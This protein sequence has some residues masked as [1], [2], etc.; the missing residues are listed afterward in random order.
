MNEHPLPWDACRGT[1]PHP[2]S[3]THPSCVPVFRPQSDDYESGSDTPD[4]AA[5][6][7]ELL[8]SVR[9]TIGAFAAPD[10]IH[11]A[12]RYNSPSLNPL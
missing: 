2:S 11:W 5:L 12:P 4:I 9:N 10:V 3:L 8:A 7:K 1:L 6:K